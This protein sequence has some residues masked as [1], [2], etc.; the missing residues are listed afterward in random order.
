MSTVY[1]PFRTRAVIELG[2]H[3]WRKQLLPLGDV[4]YKGRLITFS[5]N[6]F[7]DL[8][9]AFNDK[10][11]N[12]VP[13]QLAGPDNKHTNAVKNRAGTIRGLELADDGLDLI[14]ETDDEGD[15][16]LRK[17]PDLG[18]SARIYEDYER[19]ADGKYW[20]AALQHVLATLDPHI[21]GMRQWQRLEPVALANA[22]G[23]VI[24]LTNG[25]YEER[26][27]ETVPKTR[28]DLKAIL[29]KIRD[30]GDEADLSD[31]ELDQLLAITEAM[32]GDPDGD[33]GE[34]TDEELDELIAAAEADEPDEEDGDE[35]D[36]EESDPKLVAAA[37]R[38]RRA[39]ELA[40]SRL[41]SQAV[42][43]SAVQQRL[44]NQSW[45][46]EVTELAS[47]F[48]IPPF[49]AEK[50]KPLLFGSGRIVELSNG[51]EV[52][53]GE[54]M[55]D[56]LHSIG[57]QIKL[58]DLSGLIGSGLPEPDDQRTEREAVDQE[59]KEFLELVKSTYHF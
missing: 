33:D 3:R 48:G 47:D 41:E 24:D 13:F 6:Y 53:A 22:G 23:R 55:R 51:E 57:K 29:A 42:E 25:Q 8:I 40:N 19:E 16:L 35:E 49:I 26:E 15:E 1:T 44:D 59:R 4:R 9:K 36:A 12:A 20:P 34:L 56:V 37:N 27:E 11:V 30:G 32:T 58:L 52:D 17:Y 54:V 18:V 7:T 5:K 43:L 28:T 50:A 14:L 46:N 45:L 39:L 10:A 31:E 21:P 38:N 2:N